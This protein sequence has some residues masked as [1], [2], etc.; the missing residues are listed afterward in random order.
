M[1]TQDDTQKKGTFNYIYND[2]EYELESHHLNII[3]EEIESI[4]PDNNDLV[5]CSVR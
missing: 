5:L 3:V 4:F 2:A 1:F